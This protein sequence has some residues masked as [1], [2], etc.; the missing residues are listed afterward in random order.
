MATAA[1]TAFGSGYLSIEDV[2][3]VPLQDAHRAHDALEN[4]FGG[5][6]LVLI[7]IDGIS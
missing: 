2:Q 6:S 3:E 7:P 1:F 4:R 5:G